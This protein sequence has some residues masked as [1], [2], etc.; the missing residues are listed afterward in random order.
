MNPILF[1]TT[2]FCLILTAHKLT[3]CDHMERGIHYNVQ[4]LHLHNLYSYYSCK[5]TLLMITKVI[6][7]C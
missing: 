4:W 7:T 1:L 3:F 2:Q 5:A 6:E